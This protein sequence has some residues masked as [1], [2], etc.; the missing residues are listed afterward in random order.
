[1]LRAPTAD[2][3][4][5]RPFPVSFCGNLLRCRNIDLRMTDEELM[6][7]FEASTID[8]GRFGHHEHV[9]LTWLYLQRYGRPEVEHRLLTGLAALAARAGK[10]EKFSAPLT[11]AWIDRIDRAR[12]ALGTHSFADLLHQHPE[13]GERATAREITQT[14]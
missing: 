10:P 2:S 9:R 4:S 11:L 6:T 7:G 14:I 13:L 5:L 3:E 12:S 8:P 1:M